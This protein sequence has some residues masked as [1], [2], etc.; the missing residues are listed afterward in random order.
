M[1]AIECETITT[2]ILNYNDRD[3]NCRHVEFG[4]LC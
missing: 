2:M 3:V 1:Q 4:I